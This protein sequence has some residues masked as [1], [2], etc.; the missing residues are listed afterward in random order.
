MERELC[1]NRL[2]GITWLI[3]QHKDTKLL[4]LLESNC[5]SHKMGI[6]YMIFI[7]IGNLSLDFEWKWLYSKIYFKR[8]G[9]LPE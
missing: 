7:N 8:Y 1:R 5:Y 9:Y 3:Q 4:E 6:P 2:F